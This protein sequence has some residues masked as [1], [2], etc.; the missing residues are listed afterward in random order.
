[1]PS[2]TRDLN[3][4]LIALIATV[5][6]T[7]LF[8]L[9]VGVQA[10]FQFEQNKEAYSKNSVT[11]SYDLRELKAEQRAN[12]L[13]AADPGTGQR[14]MG[15]EMAM[16]AVVE[17]YADQPATLAPAA[18]PLTPDDAATGD[19]GPNETTPEG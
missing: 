6:V 19:A 10:W 9:I 7:L 17:K 2:T 4:P 14:G 8:V 15:I 16:R 18:T 1:M 3:V 5:G 11:D 13:P 12:L